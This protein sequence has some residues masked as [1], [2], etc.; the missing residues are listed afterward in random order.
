MVAW[1]MVP[2]LL[3]SIVVT[4]SSVQSDHASDFSNTLMELITFLAPIAAV[5]GFVTLVMTGVQNKRRED[6][7]NKEVWPK[8]VHRYNALRYCERCH[9]LFDPQ[10]RSAGGSEQGFAKMMAYLN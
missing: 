7:L 9:L 2:G 6:R 1:S 8:Q 3:S 4:G 10:G 5:L